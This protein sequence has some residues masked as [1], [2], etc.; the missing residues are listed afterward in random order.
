MDERTTRLA[1]ILRLAA[2][3]PG[4]RTRFQAAGLLAADGQ[5]LVT[6]WQPAFQRLTPLSKATVRSQPGQFLVSAAAITYHSA[7]S[8]SQGEHFHCFAGRD[9]QQARAAARQ[10]SLA[11]WG[12]SATTP[13]INVASRLLPA[14]EQD[15]TLIGPIDSPLGDRLR[16]ELTAQPAILRG[17]PSRLCEVAMLLGSGDRPWPTPL[18]VI[19]TGELLYEQQHALLA[20]CFQ[21]P[22]VN[23]Y[24]CQEAG[25]SGLTCP[26]AHRL[27]L[28]ADRC[29]LEVVAGELL[30]TD[31]HNEHLPLV[32]YL[33]GDRLRLDPT[34]CLCGR[35]GPTAR[36]LGRSE[37]RLRTRADWR[38]PGEVPMPPL[39][40]LSHYRA[41]RVNAERLAIQI[42]PSEL[43]PDAAHP[44]KLDLT[45][46]Q[47]WARAHFGAI[48]LTIQSSEPPPE[49]PVAEPT[50]LTASEWAQRLTHETWTTAM[51]DLPPGI[52]RS[53][54]LLWRE[55]VQ[56]TVIANR[57]LSVAARTHFDRLLTAA[58]HPDPAVEAAI[59]RILLLAL[60]FCADERE[61]TVHYQTVARRLQAVAP[62]ALARLIP[63]L[64]L[65]R[66]TAIA[67]WSDCDLPS[68]RLDRFSLHHLLAAF[69]AAVPR[70]RHGRRLA[71]GR[72]SPLPLAWTPLPALLIGDLT[73][74]A[75]RFHPAILAMWVQFVQGVAPA[76]V[77]LP[78]QPFL[79]AWLD[80]RATLLADRADLNRLAD[81]QAAAT[82]PAE[83]SRAQLERA[84]YL[85]ASD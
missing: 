29:W 77:E 46:L 25:V 18:A 60:S 30:A 34:P 53:A 2:T 61:T 54:A 80:W 65:D 14:G 79:R 56:P 3:A 13:V 28:D 48:A 41:V 9:W 37:E 84:Y 78:R 7:T 57:G 44:P 64:W 50:P 36:L 33:V 32:R 52:A 62:Q 83:Q 19:C 23:E 40:G 43:S 49:P 69:E 1:K 67:A 66:E 17:Y 70:A 45:P 21:A 75:A 31:L 20:R 55:L 76:K 8:G 74:F 85:L 51:N 35:P 16:Q 6:D 38:S 82:S 81:L 63:T 71:D 27:H 10:R 26:E 5:A 73:T 12:L 72:E 22:I 39:P 11:R 15:R 42:W 58:R 68:G 47:T 24:G 59:A 4:N